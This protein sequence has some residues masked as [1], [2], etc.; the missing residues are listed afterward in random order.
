LLVWVVAVAVAKVLFLAILEVQGVV[1]QSW[2]RLE[3]V[4]WR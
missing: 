2:V 4:V 3:Q 1:V